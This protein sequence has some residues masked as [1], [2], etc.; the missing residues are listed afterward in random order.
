MLAL[1]AGQGVLPQILADRCAPKAIRELEGYPSGLPGARSFRIEQLGTLLQE[2]RAEGI[3]EVCFAGAIRRPPLDPAKVDA[4]T[5]PLV[6]RMLATLQLGDDAV[7]RTAL[8]FFEEAGFAVRGVDAY[9]PELLPKPGILT[10]AQPGVRD[11]KDATRAAEVH[12]ALASADVG[13]GCVVANGLVLAVEA[14]GGTDWMLRSLSD[15]RR[16][17]GPDGGLLFKAP[18]AGQDR[19][20]DLPVIGPET[21][22]NVQKAELSGIAIAAGGVLVLQ[23]DEIIAAANA[24]GL[25]VWIRE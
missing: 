18:K 12:A 13:Q 22:A 17:E 16:P 3:T 21:V 6:P 19:R 25:F 14:H 2:L 23:L 5:M 20:V 15:G 11:L 1:I 24:E 4:A 9:L 10:R 7:L 8:G